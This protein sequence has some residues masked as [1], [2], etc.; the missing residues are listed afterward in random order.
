[1]SEHER[2][3]CPIGTLQICLGMT[4]AVRSLSKDDL[5]LLRLL[6]SRGAACTRSR[7]VAMGGEVRSFEVVGWSDVIR[8]M[9]V[10]G[11]F[12]SSWWRPS[13]LSQP[14]STLAVVVVRGSGLVFVGALRA[15]NGTGRF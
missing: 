2:R 12:A 11:W 13:R 10:V 5:L 15:T 8:L 14:D 7:G 9:F 1:M 3:H 6:S 4:H